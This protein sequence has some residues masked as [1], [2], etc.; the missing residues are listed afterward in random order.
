MPQVAAAATVISSAELERSYSCF[1]RTICA[2]LVRAQVFEDM[3][4]KV[5]ETKSYDAGDTGSMFRNA[6]DKACKSS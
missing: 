4:S 5:A 6:L 3:M 2:G 1:N